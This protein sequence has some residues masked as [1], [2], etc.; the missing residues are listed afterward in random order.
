MAIIHL[1][2]PGIWVREEC[3]AKAAIAIANGSRSDLK[4]IH[5][6]LKCLNKW[7]S[8]SNAFRAIADRRCSG[9]SFLVC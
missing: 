5:P 6:T 1:G 9:Y 3:T 8:R 4:I 2:L 7:R